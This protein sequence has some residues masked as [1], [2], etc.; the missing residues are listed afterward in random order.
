MNVAVIGGAANELVAAHYLAR[1][2]HRVSVIRETSEE[3]EGVWITGWT[4]PQIVA[5]LDLRRHGFTIEQRDPWI[6]ALLPGGG[7]LKLYRDIG[8]SIES[9]RALSVK[10][11]AN[12]PH[13]CTRMHALS[14]L[15]SV[16]YSA[17]PPELFAADTEAMNG[18]GCGPQAACGRPEP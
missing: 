13:F 7:T 6:E 17:P 2:G 15:L 9:I 4:P 5:D 10:D 1:A 11:A 14:S 18:Y 8:R 16:L 12:W 3:N